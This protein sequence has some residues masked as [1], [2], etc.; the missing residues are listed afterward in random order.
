MSQ[1]HVE[2]EIGFWNIPWIKASRLR[3]FLE[4]GGQ[5]PKKA[6]N[7]PGKVTDLKS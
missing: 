1:S 2:K 4:V 3:H 7:V 6:S 5:L